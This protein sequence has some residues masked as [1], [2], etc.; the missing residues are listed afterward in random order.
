MSANDAANMVRGRV[1][2]GL[3]RAHTTLKQIAEQQHAAAD[4][5]AGH[6]RDA[7]RVAVGATLTHAFSQ[8]PSH[9]SVAKAAA[10]AHGIH[11]RHVGEHLVAEQAARLG[12]AGARWLLGQAAKQDQ[13]RAA[14][15]SGGAQE[16][17]A[18]PIETPR[19]SE[20]V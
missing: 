4:E 15:N 11:S 14:Q 7:G 5:D 12:A 9:R 18:A 1:I 16:P 8:D 20:E 19:P 13:Y 3:Q 17:D 2:D 6:A 10:N